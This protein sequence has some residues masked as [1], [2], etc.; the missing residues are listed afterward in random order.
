ME[1]M[2]LPPSARGAPLRISMMA[3]PAPAVPPVPPPASAGSWS[4][5]GDVSV[6]GSTT[7]ASPSG[8]ASPKPSAMPPSRL[9]MTRMRGPM[10]SIETGTTLPESSAPPSTSTPARGARATRLPDLSFNSM[11]RRRTWGTLLPPVRSTT[12]PPTETAMAGRLALM[13]FSTVWRRKSS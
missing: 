11:S 12:T 9:R 8:A 1:P 4:L 6:S 7:T 10:S 2:A 5:L 13:R 3:A